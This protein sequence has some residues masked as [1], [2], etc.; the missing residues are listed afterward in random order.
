M[1]PEEV[2]NE[3]TMG[4]ERPF[5]DGFIDEGSVKIRVNEISTSINVQP[6]D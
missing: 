5:V 2:R 4:E 1:V 6:D 3:N